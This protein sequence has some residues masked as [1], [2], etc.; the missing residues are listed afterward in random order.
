MLAGGENSLQ[1]RFFDLT[2]DLLFLIQKVLQ[3]TRFVAGQKPSKLDY[4]FVSKSTCSI[5]DEMQYL[6][7]LGSSDHVGI[8]WKLKYGCKEK[9]RSSRNT[10]R[11]YWRGNYL[12]MGY[13]LARTDF[14]WF[15]AY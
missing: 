6:A 1:A 4:V 2:H 11:A 14:F 7:P 9:I 5:I 10:K 3:P 15:S 12:K 8:L 13:I